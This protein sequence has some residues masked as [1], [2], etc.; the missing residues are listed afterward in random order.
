V[1]PCGALHRPALVAIH[2][3]A[4]PPAEQWADK[5]MAE[6]LAMPGVFGF[7]ESRGGMILARAVAGEVEILTLAVAPQARRQGIGRALVAQVASATP[8]QP[9]FL[10]V[11]ADNAAG[12]ALYRTAGFLECGCRRDY[13]GPG[14]DA[15]ILRR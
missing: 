1:T 5:A 9:I 4:F 8:G 2:A 14:R 11:A 10:E 13:Y 12:Q 3:A 6:I 7:I 15:L